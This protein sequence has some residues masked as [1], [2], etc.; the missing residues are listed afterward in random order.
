MSLRE[1]FDLTERPRPPCR[2][3][4]ILLELDADDADWLA[5]VLDSQTPAWQVSQGLHRAG[6]PTSTTTVKV[7]RR[8]ECSCESR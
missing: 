5:D 2:V 6:Y 7:H 3:G 8:K 4:R 1:H